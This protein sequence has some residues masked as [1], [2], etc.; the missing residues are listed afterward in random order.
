MPKSK[1]TPIGLKAQNHK[2]P[3]RDQDTKIAWVIDILS[4]HAITQS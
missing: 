2:Q 4:Q 3:I 1:F